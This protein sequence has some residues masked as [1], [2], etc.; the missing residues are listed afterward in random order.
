MHAGNLFLDFTKLFLDFTK[1]FL[2]IQKPG[3]HTLIQPTFHFLEP[4]GK[5]VLHQFRNDA[6]GHASVKGKS[7]DLVKPSSL[8]QK[9]GYSAW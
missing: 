3:I 5:A 4:Q 8:V 1:L 6:K 2:D 9:P 7:Q